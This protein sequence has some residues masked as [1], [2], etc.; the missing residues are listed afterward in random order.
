M[1][2][3]IEV[4]SHNHCCHGKAKSIAI[5]SGSEDLVIQ[6]AKYMRPIILLSVI[7]LDCTIFVHIIL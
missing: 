4:Y 5:L 2:R 3:N 1:S 6:L 7:C